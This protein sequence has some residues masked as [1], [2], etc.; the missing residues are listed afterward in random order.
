MVAGTFNAFG[1]DG[2][3]VEAAK[4]N[5]AAGMVSIMFMVFA[6]IFGLL[7]KKFSFSGWKESVISIVFDVL[8]CPR[9]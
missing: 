5:G 9:S 3:M 2:A 4:T 6:V 8:S 1:A 7:Q